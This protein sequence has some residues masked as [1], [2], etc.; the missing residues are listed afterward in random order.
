LLQMSVPGHVRPLGFARPAGSGPLR[1][2]SG[3]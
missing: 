2:E 1:S 3:S